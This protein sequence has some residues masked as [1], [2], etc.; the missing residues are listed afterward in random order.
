MKS[1]FPEKGS[2]Y[3][4]GLFLAYHK[5]KAFTACKFIHF[6]NHSYLT[7]SFNASYWIYSLILIG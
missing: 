3:S 1:S 4:T 2:D 7:Y 5:Y 6:I